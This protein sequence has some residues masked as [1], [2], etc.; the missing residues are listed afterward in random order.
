M[1]Q[2][3]S[4]NGAVTELNSTITQTASEINAKVEK[5]VDEETITGA[6]LILKING[7]TSE[8]KLNADKIELSAN[9]IL[10]LLAGNTINLTSKN[11]VIASTNFNVDKDGNVTCENIN[12]NSGKIQLNPGNSSN[13][14]FRIGENLF[15]TEEYFVMGQ[16]ELYGDFIAISASSTSTTEINVN[17]GGKQTRIL[18]SEIQTPKLTCPNIDQSSLE[19]IKKNISKF[20]KNATDIINNSDIYEY[21]LKSDK[22][23]DKKLIGFIIGEN[24]KTPAEVIDKNEQAVSLYS[25]I[26]ILWKGFQEQQAKVEKLEERVEQLE[27]E[28]HK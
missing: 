16:E 7:D 18:A 2:L 20:T 5:K 25:T 24:Y 6:Y 22:D 21:N 3:M 27:K 23:T 12:I 26:G 28:V 14:N 4:Q 8:A 11:L 17:S 15:M 1:Q 10:N 9:D 13:P 19:S